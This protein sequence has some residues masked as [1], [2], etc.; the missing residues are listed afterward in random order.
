MR[1]YKKVYTVNVSYG[2]LVFLSCVC[3]FYNTKLFLLKITWS[4]FKLI[5]DFVSFF[6]IF[7]IS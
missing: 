4:Q 6:D 5:S 7:T 3:V 1:K 2:E